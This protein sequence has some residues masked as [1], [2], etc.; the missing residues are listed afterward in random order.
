MIVDKDHTRLLLRV[1]NPALIQKVLPGQTKVIDFEGH[2]LAVKHSLDAT[3]ILRNLGIKAPSPIRYYYRWTGRYKPMAHQIETADFLTLNRKAFVLNEMGTSKTASALWAMDYLMQLGRVKKCLVVAPLSTLE[4]VWL[5]EVFLWVMHRSAVVLH[6]SREKRLQLLASDADVYVINHDGLAVIADEIKDRDDINLTIVDEAAAYRNGQNERYSVLKSVVAK[7][8][9]RLWLM[10]GTPC[11]NAPTDAWALAKLVN[12]MNVPTYFTS[13]KRQTMQQV[14][15]Y[16]WVPRI[17]SSEM[18]YNA[19][20]PAVRFRK[21]DCLDLPPVT[22]SKRAVKLTPEQEKAYATMHKFMVMQA[23]STPITAVNAADQI[24]K[25]RQILCGVVK[26]PETGE[27]DEIPHQPRVN[28]LLECIEEASAK[29]IVVV[30]YK[31]IIEALE[32]E[33]EKD[34]SCAVLNGDV[35][36]RQRNKIITAFT[37]TKT[38]RVLLCHPKVMAHGLNLS[39]ADTIVFYAPIYSNEDSEQVMDRINRTGQKLPMTIIRLGAVQLEWNIYNVVEARRRGQQS[40]LE[41]YKQ[42]LKS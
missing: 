28:V 3:K 18:A 20:Q 27:Y 1:R 29:V 19:M 35:S 16:K 10:T 23:R 5:D 7:E 8:Q 32:R 37:K 42:E 9:M 33:V 14:T 26:N 39:V 4:R 36:I 31:G 17:G 24:G 40:I 12:P 41:L 38:P 15:T 13:W 11:P 2:N 22:F 6:G 30:P 25:L 34:Y 21:K